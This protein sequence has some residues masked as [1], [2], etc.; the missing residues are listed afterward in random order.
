M[1]ENKVAE[2][3]EQIISQ[4]Q[5]FLTETISDEEIEMEQ[6]RAGQ[7]GQQHTE[8]DGE[9]QQRLV[10]LLDGQV[11]QE[12]TEE[13]HHKVLPTFT[14]EEGHDAHLAEEV[15]QTLCYI[16]LSSHCG[17]GNEHEEGQK[18]K[19]FNVFHNILF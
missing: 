13:D 1:E 19:K 2:S 18:A 15:A 5:G 7:V 3:A 6:L 9:E 11:E 17:S 10:F 16:H 4:I 8:G 14:N 12:A